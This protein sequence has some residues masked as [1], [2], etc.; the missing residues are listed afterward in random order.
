MAQNNMLDISLAKQRLKSEA[1]KRRANIR[2]ANSPM[3]R[4]LGYKPGK[5][6]QIVIAILISV[7]FCALALAFISFGHGVGLL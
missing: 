1:A 4:S 5:L 3:R 2:A 7:F 6:G